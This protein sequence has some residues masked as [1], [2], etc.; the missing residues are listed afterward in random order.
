VPSKSKKQH[1]FMQAVAHSL[2][3]ARKARVP[4][5]VGREYVEADK[6]KAGKSKTS[7]SEKGAKR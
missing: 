1:D 2:S 3:F 4:Q 5:S 6:R 7:K